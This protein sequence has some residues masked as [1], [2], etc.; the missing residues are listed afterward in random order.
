MNKFITKDHN[1]VQWESMDG[2]YYCADGDG[3]VVV[4]ASNGQYAVSDQ[5]EL[6]MTTTNEGLAFDAANNI[7]E[8]HYPAVYEE[9]TAWG[10]EQ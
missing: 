10:E 2:I 3:F 4:E 8:E 9:F 1:K 7:L 5:G 6:V